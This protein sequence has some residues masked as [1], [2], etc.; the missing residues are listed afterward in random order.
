MF[1]LIA[2]I[3]APLSAMDSQETTSS[4]FGWKAGL[5]LTAAVAGTGLAA[6]LA[7]SSWNRPATKPV[8]CVRQK[9]SVRW[10]TP[11]AADIAQMEQ[12]ERAAQ[13]AALQELEGQ[14]ASQESMILEDFRSAN[15]Q[16]QKIEIAKQAF[17]YIDSPEQETED[18]IRQYVQIYSHRLKSP[19]LDIAM[20]RLFAA[21]DK[22]AKTIELTK[23]KQM[24]GLVYY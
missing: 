9:S 8:G 15:A 2:S 17:Q 22:A 11:T 6:Y 7:Y 20:N 3:V 19:D 4:G 21:K 10:A 13:D 1:A 14:A 24:L 18:L 23:I 5:G 12:E 16:T